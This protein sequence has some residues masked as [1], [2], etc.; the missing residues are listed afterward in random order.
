MTDLD[1]T[2]TGGRPGM[3]AGALCSLLLHGLV[4]ALAIL[5]FP[6]VSAPPPVEPEV[7]PVELVA[8]GEQTTAPPGP[9]ADRPAETPP[10]T[11]KPAPATTA[12]IPPATIKPHAGKL[13]KP[14]PPEDFDSRLRQ[15]DRAQ[16]HAKLA[17]EDQAES[18]HGMGEDA[19]TANAGVLGPRAAVS[20]RDYLRAQILRRWNFDVARL[21]SRFWIIAVH[22]VL[23][24]DGTVET[25][26]AVMDPRYQKLPDYRALAQSAR[27][28]V[29]V[30]SP[31]HL[32]PGTP[33]GLRDL[34]L[35]FDPRA[36]LR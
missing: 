10:E 9:K 36:A 28:A 6:A 16:P 11:A 4:A 1:S 30:S 8:L 26:E 20:V 33:A 25:A 7:I 22:V 34:T 12:P 31:L 24:P 35:D 27:N 3:G 14:P 23:S 18:G 19:N 32:P 13:M 21:G 29:L 5:G 17:P 15:A 2:H